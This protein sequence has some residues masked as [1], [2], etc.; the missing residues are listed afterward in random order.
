MDPTV[1][2]GRALN[3]F[4]ILTMIIVFGSNVICYMIVWGKIRHVEGMMEKFQDAE[5]KDATKRSRRSA[6]SMA[7]IVLAFLFQWS[8]YVA[9]TLWMFFGS[10]PNELLVA[11]V[12][13]CNLGGVFNATAYTLMRKYNKSCDRAEK[14]TSKLPGDVSL[15]TSATNVSEISAKI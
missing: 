5:V 8:L 1:A 4:Y 12:F 14:R 10:P 2:A 3:T 15:S 11:D 7:L 6:Q 9:Y 13:I